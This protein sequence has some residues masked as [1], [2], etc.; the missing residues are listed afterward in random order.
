MNT[1]LASKYY[2]GKDPRQVPAYSFA[3]ASRYL[4]LPRSTL[5]S[6]VRGRNYV[7]NSMLSYSEP[8]ITQGIIAYSF[9]SFDVLI[10][11]H[12]LKALRKIHNVSMKSLRAALKTAQAKF[13]IRNLLLSPHLKAGAGELF[14]D[15]Y[16]YLI[17]LSKSG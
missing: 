10:E 1:N 12:I 15:R 5:M 8:L 14:L 11:A 2:G 9:L 7:Y 16:G 3:E 4:R 17:N 13:G 6:W